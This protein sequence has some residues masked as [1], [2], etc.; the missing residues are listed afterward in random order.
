MKTK[1]FVSIAI[2]VVVLVVGVSCNRN[3]TN[4]TAKP[5][6]ENGIA[7]NE[8]NQIEM[9]IFDDINV[10]GD[11]AISSNLSG[12]LQYNGFVYYE[13]YYHYYADLHA[14]SEETG[15]DHTI[16]KFPNVGS[17]WIKDNVLYH[18]SF[19][20]GF[21]KM[22]MEDYSVEKICGA[23]TVFGNFK[24]FTPDWI[25]MQADFTTSDGDGEIYRFRYD[26][27]ERTVL[28]N[29]N[30][31]YLQSD[32]EY[33]YYFSL[34]EN[35]IVKMGMDGSG[36]EI[37]VDNLRKG[38]NGKLSYKIGQYYMTLHNGWIYYIDDY[39]VYKVQKDGQNNT[40]LHTTATD[41]VVN[42][43]W[44]IMLDREGNEDFWGPI[45]FLSW[46]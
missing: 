23:D 5:S 35:A 38:S 2:I 10:P 44:V 46:I 28:S 26:G 20:D 22:D 36:K 9:S 45:V 40:S 12:I 37:L 16:A 39:Q 41:L 14:R 42:S 7:V 6:N 11:S 8:S 30:G 17:M 4:T 3:D 33:L 13:R 27:S 1:I 25:Y 29:D 19:N 15:E 34:R 21:H 43:S 31:L 18:V 24:V 32:G